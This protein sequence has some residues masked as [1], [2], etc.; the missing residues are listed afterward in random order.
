[1]SVSW[2]INSNPPEYYGVVV[3]GVRFNTRNGK[4]LRLGRTADFDSAEVLA[5]G[6]AVVLKRDGVTYF[7]G[8]VRRRPRQARGSRE[9]QDIIVED[10]WAELEET[11]YHEP[12]AVGAGSVNLPKG[13]LGLSNTGAVQSTG[14]DIGDVIDY[15]ISVGVAIQKGDI[16]V[17]LTLW[18]SLIENVSCAEVIR[19]SMRLHP[20]W[21]L[22]LDH[23]TTPPTLHARAA[24]NLQARSFNL[25]GGEVTAVNVDPLDERVPAAV[26]ILYTTAT[27]IDGVVYRDGVI[28]KFP[29]DH[30]GEG[31]GVLTTTIEL[32]GAQMQFQ[33]S[34][35]Q[36]RNLPT[37]QE[38]AKAWLKLKYPELADIPDANFKVSEFETTLFNE[39]E[40]LP[41]PVNPNATRLS[42]S[43][44]TDLPRELVRGNIEDWMRVKVGKIKIEVA[45]ESQGAATED[46]KKIIARMNEKTALT[47]VATN[48]TTKIYKS[49][50]Q[51]TLG[52]NAPSGV[53]EAVYTALATTQ[54][55][56]SVTIEA[57]D[58]SALRMEGC[59]VNLTNGLAAW[60]SMEAL[61]NSVD[62]DIQSGRM[63]IGFGP[64]E[65][66]APQDWIE[67]QRNLRNRFPNWISAA[68]RNSNELGAEN[69]PSSKGDTVGGFDGPETI[70]LPGGSGGGGNNGPFAP[71]SAT[72]DPPESGTFNVVI[73]EGWVID[74]LP[75]SGVEAVALIMPV[76]KDG[77]GD[78]A[79]NASTR[80]EFS[81]SS[82]DFLYCVYNT[83]AK[84]KVTAETDEEVRI[85]VSSTDKGGTHYQ[86]EDPLDADGTKGEYWVKLLK[87]E[88][89]SGSPEIIPYCQSDIEHYHELPTLKNT[90]AARR[91]YK[92]R[93]TTTGE[94]EFRSLAQGEESTSTPGEF[95][96]EIQID[97]SGDVLRVRGNDKFHK[98]EILDGDASVPADSK[99]TLL[100]FRDGLLADGE[101]AL[102][103]YKREVKI[104]RDDGSGYDTK[105]GLFLD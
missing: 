34:R 23:S 79:L 99:E 16:D 63:T 82:G 7:Q 73:N 31:P 40:T 60:A 32:A 3:A 101:A 41:G 55:A 90:V 18:P 71:I 24:S 85:V 59:K 94:Y 39:A 70:S 28:D 33:K 86:P 80:P 54:H 56:G 105:H 96:D 45:L 35:I 4:Q 48:A 44:A 8:K 98:V 65:Q 51:W 17:G 64:P 43:D 61:V 20:D 66:L 68:E 14:A 50:S 100:N 53:A 91:I 27:I 19:M 37:D 21:E 103:L 84:G 13:Y 92:G 75:E 42:V 12:W 36:T 102:T 67:L 78:I 62:M 74:R 49:V 97:E 104:C 26:K 15:A 58:V 5:N 9:G 30:S 95:R 6:A 72:E 89:V 76:K 25:T 10:A 2:L 88:V 47:V 1:M 57:E 83:D 52:E 46:Q 87:L 29:A 81:M 11:T 69:D 93:N 38:T 22:W 77:G